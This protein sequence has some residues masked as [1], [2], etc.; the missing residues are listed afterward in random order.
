MLFFRMSL[1]C[2]KSTHPF[3][4]WRYVN[5]V[6][7]QVNDLSVCTLRTKFHTSTFIVSR[8]WVLNTRFW[9][10]WQ[11]CCSI[12]F[13]LT[14]LLHKQRWY[15]CRLVATVRKRL[16]TTVTSYE[17]LL[18][19]FPCQINFNELTNVTPAIFS[20]GG[21]E[22]ST[23]LNYFG[24]R[25]AYQKIQRWAMVASHKFT[26]ASPITLARIEQLPL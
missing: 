6:G 13:R 9:G 10:G 26:S 14:N 25:Q 15:L 16:I 7:L 12:S 24:W 18:A 19:L 3:L 1:F 8:V 4:T 2:G 22:K 20:C 21:N 5:R 11:L 23:M 17:N